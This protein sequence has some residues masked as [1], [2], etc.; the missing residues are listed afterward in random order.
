MIESDEK[1]SWTKHEKAEEVKRWNQ[2]NFIFRRG[3]GVLSEPPD[4]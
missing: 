3:G 1:I 4:K 2:P